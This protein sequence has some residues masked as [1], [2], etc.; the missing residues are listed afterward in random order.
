MPVVVFRSTAVTSVLLQTAT[1]QFC[2]RLLLL[3]SIKDCYFSV[4]SQSVTSRSVTGWYV[5]V[6]SHLPAVLTSVTEFYF[7]V[8]LRVL[9]VVTC[10]FCRAGNGLL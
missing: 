1:S 3:G 9:E 8:L 4:L 7:S 2:Y 5:K 10:Y 6:L